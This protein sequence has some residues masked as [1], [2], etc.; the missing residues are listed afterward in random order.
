MKNCPKC[1]AQLPDDAMFCTNCGNAFQSQQPQNPYGAQPQ[2]NQ[3]PN[4]GGY[5]A[6]M[7]NQ[8]YAQPAPVYDPYD[9]TAE[10]DA[11]DVSEN[12]I[13]ALLMYLTSIIGV[14]IAL[15]VNKNQD[16]AYLKFHMRQVLNIFVLETLAGL[17]SA[18]LWC[19]VI[20]PIAGSISVIILLVVTAICFIKTAQNKSIEAPIVRSFKFL[21]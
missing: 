8:P 9:H 15:L 17:L 11:N 18:L 3:M 21:K 1:N 19:T 13:F 7:P 4:N 20:V 10:F 2:N 5:Q 14:I 12:K 6:Q 16:S